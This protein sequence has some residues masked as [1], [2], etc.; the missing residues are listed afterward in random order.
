VQIDKEAIRRLIPHSGTMCLLDGV[1]FWDAETIECVSMTHLA[2][3]N[4]LRVEGRLLGVHLIEYGA[5]AIAVHGGLLAPVKN[6]SFRPG[7]LAAI[8]DAHFYVD[9]LDSVSSGLNVVATALMRSDAGVV[10]TIEL[11]SKEN[12]TLVEARAT[13]VFIGAASQ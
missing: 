4:P 13:V 5:Q 11:S 12:G 1:T 3:D 8:S 10:Y 6:R 2:R 7:Y 9:T